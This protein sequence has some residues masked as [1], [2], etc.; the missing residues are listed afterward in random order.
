VRLSEEG[1]ELVGL[2]DSDQS[3]QIN[4]R[5]FGLGAVPLQILTHPE[6][7]PGALRAGDAI[8]FGKAL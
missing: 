3:S 2:N 1:S 7:R 6:E 8:H 5:R 4:R